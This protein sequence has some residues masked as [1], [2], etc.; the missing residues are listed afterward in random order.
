LKKPL[1]FA[2][3]GLS[4]GTQRVLVLTEGERVRSGLRINID[5]VP[6]VT[7]LRHLEA[8]RTTIND[9]IFNQSFRVAGLKCWL[10]RTDREPSSR[11]RDYL[12][13]V[14]DTQHQ[15]A[16]CLNREDWWKFAMPEVPPLLA[17]T[18]FRGERPKIAI[19]AVSARAVGSVSGIYG[20]PA[21]CRKGLVTAFRELDLSH[22]IV[23]HSNG[24]KKVEIHQINA[25]LDELNKDFK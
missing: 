5:V 6:C 18:G 10:I 21:R 24:L 15:T 4:P 7:T 22:R 20:V 3:R 19:N 14:P 13:G 11:L 2:K 1:I 25:L 17:A 12:T 16:T 23:P 8:D 9:K